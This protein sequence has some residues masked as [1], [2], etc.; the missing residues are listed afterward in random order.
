[1]SSRYERTITTAAGTE[2][3]GGPLVG[4]PFKALMANGSDASVGVNMG[5]GFDFGKGKCAVT[6]TLK[7]AQDQKTIDWAGDLALR[8]ANNLAKEGM[9]MAWDYMQEKAG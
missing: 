9:S 3:D 1:M 6:V 8:T 4:D 2:S 7:C 5:Y